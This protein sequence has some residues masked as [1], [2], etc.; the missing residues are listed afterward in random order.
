MS[1]N[2]SSCEWVRGAL[3]SFLDGAESDLSAEEHARV[4]QHCASCVACASE[5]A[6]AKRM[7]AVM[8]TMSHDAAPPHVVTRAANEIAAGKSNVVALRPRPRSK[9]WLAVTAAAAILLVAVSADYTRRRK[10]RDVAVEEA[11]REAAIAFAYLDKYARRAGSIV[12]DDVIMRRIV[13]PVEK[14][15]EKSGVA[16]TKSSDGQS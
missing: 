1:L 14:A 15:I 5:L 7:R 3:D 16:E 2:N 8:R 6:T 13:T 11:A 10:D 4:S 12:E 9:R